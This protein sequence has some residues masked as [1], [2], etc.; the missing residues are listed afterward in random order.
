MKHQPAYGMTAE[1]TTASHDNNSLMHSAAW[2]PILQLPPCLLVEIFDLLHSKELYQPR[3]LSAFCRTCKVVYHLGTPWLYRRFQYT[4]SGNQ[5]RNLKRFYSTLEQR[6]SLRMHTESLDL[7]MPSPYNIFMDRSDYRLPSP[8][9]F[10]RV[11][12]SLEVLWSFSCVV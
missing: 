10:P 2:S 11:H 12:Q 8:S 7:A 4:V 6:D 3:D 5:F 1:I 9:W